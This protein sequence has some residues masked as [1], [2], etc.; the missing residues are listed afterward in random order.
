[1]IP[2][3]PFDR[4]GRR[5]NF[6][7]GRAKQ[8]ICLVSDVYNIPLEQL[9]GHRRF[10]EWAVPR[11]LIYWLIRKTTNKS[12]PEIGRILGRDH[13]T[14]L[15]GIRQVEKRLLADEEFRRTA[16]ILHAQFSE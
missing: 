10:R 4:I 12:L 16:T 6:P 9:M 1:M 8:I 11:Q 2:F 14:I 7:I 13:A 3:N 5:L 15:H